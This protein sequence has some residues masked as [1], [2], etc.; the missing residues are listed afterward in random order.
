MKYEKLQNIFII[1]SWCWLVVLVMLLCEFIKTV[2]A[3]IWIELLYNIYYNI[4]YIVYH[5]LLQLVISSC[6]YNIQVGYEH[7]S[8]SISHRI[9]TSLRSETEQLWK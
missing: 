8:V 2:E 1:P 3:F 4:Y 7:V 5:R 6:Q 9:F